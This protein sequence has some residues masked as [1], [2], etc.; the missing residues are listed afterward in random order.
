ME[1]EIQK[2]R[3]EF[4]KKLD[5]LKNLIQ[6]NKIEKKV[7]EKYAFTKIG[8]LEWS[9]PLG[10]MPWEEATKKCEEMGGRLP[11]RLELLNLVD[12]HSEEIEDW[13]KYN[14]FW[15]AT[16][17]SN[18]TQNA[19]YTYLPSGYTSYSAKTNSYDSRCVR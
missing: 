5:E 4:N 7:K 8:D 13:D 10:E 2:L 18:S 14:N 9:E 6:D 15:S 12:N 3:D 11:T 19:W 17:L 16:T 1:K